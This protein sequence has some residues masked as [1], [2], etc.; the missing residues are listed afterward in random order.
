[1]TTKQ[2]QV[3]KRDGSKEIFEADKINK[4]VQWATEGVSGVDANLIAMN[5]NLSLASEIHSK[6]IH[7]ALIEAA[8]NLFS[9][10]NPNYALVAG[11][12]LVFALR[13]EVWGGKNPPHLF[14]FIKRKVEQGL[15]DGRLLENYTEAEIN[16]LNEKI[17]HDRDL[18]LSYSAIKQL[19]EKYLISNKS[20]GEV[21]ET[22]SFAYMVMAMTSHIN[23]AS[24]KRVTF[25]KKAYEMYTK[26]K[27]S[28]PSPLMSKLRT[29]TRS[30]ASC[31]LIPVLDSLDSINAA[32]TW[33]AQATAKGYGIGLDTSRIRPINSPI[34][35][36]E[37]LHT[38]VIPYLKT[39]E[40]IVIATLQGSRG[41]SATVTFPIWHYEMEDILQL[42]NNRGT[43]ANRVRR[44]DYSIGVSKLFLQRL[45]TR[46]KITLFNPS[47]VTGLIEAFGT[48]AFDDL[49]IRYENDPTIKMKKVVDAT[50]L[51][52]TLAE[53]RIET[54]R[55]YLLFVDNANEH[56]PWINKVEFSNLCQEILQDITPPKS[57]DDP[58]GEI[59]ICTLSAINVL[60]IKSDADLEEVCAATVRQLDN[61]LDDQDYFST[62]ARNFATKKRS[63]GIGI[64]NLAA[65]LAKNGLK[66]SDPASVLFVDE[67]MEKIQYYCLR[68]SV[69]LAKERG[70][71]EKFN[72]SKY[73]LGILPIDTYKKTVDEFCNRPLSMDWETLRKD[74]VEFGLRHMTLTAMM[75][76][77][78]SSVCLESTNGVDPIQSK[79]SIKE[80]KQ[81]FVKQIVPGAKQWEYET[82]FDMPNNENLIKIYAVIQKYC[83]MSISA[84]HF[85]SKD[86]LSVKRVLSDI[87]LSYKAGLKTLYYSKKDDGHKSEGMSDSGC[88]GG[89]CSI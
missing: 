43:D 47:E 64:T 6:D 15:Y 7:K 44:L 32:R 5:A 83:D 8:D 40:S 66:Y 57:L 17:Q 77:E 51:F 62:Q 72:E 41:G 88:A 53:E 85:Y 26:R 52:T 34:R 23:E 24:N 30:Y 63:L 2:I 56:S 75:P 33:T 49:Y 13:K 16:K 12:L 27:M 79:F 61:I 35:N 78:A 58:N 70:K 10:Q 80:S 31:C 46:G 19:V 82:C 54:G 59:G 18:N 86:K 84:N 68:A 42:K 1:M 9:E 14:D 50:E 67:L 22:P 28:L 89:A 73:S 25:V 76:C 3:I 36:G 55:I 37:V 29:K 74:I 39:F 87:L 4:V 45:M 60:E 11:R 21:F 71:V 20:T 48:P 38:G 81:G 69:E 65:L